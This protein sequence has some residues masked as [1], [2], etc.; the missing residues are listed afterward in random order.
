MPIAA[1]PVTKTYAGTGTRT[2]FPTG[3]I[4]LTADDVW[5][6][7]VAR[8]G[9]DVTAD[10]ALALSGGQDEHHRPRY[11]IVTI[12]PAP[13][14][15]VTVIL[16]RSEW[17]VAGAVHPVRIE[18]IPPAAVTLAVTPPAVQQAPPAPALPPPT[19]P[20][21]AP[22]V[23]A[24]APLP[25]PSP[26]PN[27]EFVLT[28]MAALMQQMVAESEARTQHRLTAVLSGVADELDRLPKGKP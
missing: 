10:Y 27:L 25:E 6:R 5:V 13:A 8:D 22:R 15:G 12:A 11:G 3:F 23:I 9:T 28:E 24:P 19:S 4:F 2:D 7:L 20:V 1:T 16:V 21:P 17:M 14:V 18:I 26:A